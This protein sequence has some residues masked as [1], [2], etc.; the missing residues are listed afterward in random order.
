[1]ADAAEDLAVLRDYLQRTTD[2]VA[3]GKQDAQQVRGISASAPSEAP[4]G[5]YQCIA[6][7]MDTERRPN[8]VARCPTP[9]AVDELP[10]PGV[11][12][13]GGILPLHPLWDHTPLSG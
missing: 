8:S 10:P 11:G 4:V 6:M 7:A 3:L 12:A 13:C 1:M 5:P 2:G 9:L